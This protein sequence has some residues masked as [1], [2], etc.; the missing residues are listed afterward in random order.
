[1]SLPVP[2]DF[3]QER[4]ILVQR[5]A[6]NDHPNLDALRAALQARLTAMLD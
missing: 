1:M 4:M 6:S 2:F 5:S 3:A